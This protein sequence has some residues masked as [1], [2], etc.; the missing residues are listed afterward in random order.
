MLGRR[1]FFIAAPVVWNSLPLHLRSLS[2]S[3]SQFQTGSRLI[4]SGWSLSLT[5]PLRTIEAIE[6]N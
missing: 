1:S 3:C 4:F 2:I 6:L 5:F